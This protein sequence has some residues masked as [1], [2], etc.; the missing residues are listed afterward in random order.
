MQRLAAAA[1]AALHKNLTCGK[2]SAEIAAAVA[3][4]DRALKGVELA[5]VLERVEA[6][7]AADKL[8]RE[9]EKYG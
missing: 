8:R 5:D 4:F 2:P 9:R 7:E 3:L 1:A 6:L